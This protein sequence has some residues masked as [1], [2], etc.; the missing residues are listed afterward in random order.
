MKLTEQTFGPLAP[1]LL[2]L[3]SAF[4]A[5]GIRLVLV[6]GFGLVLRRQWR[7]E[8]GVQTLIE[9]VPPARATEDFDVLLKLEILEDPEQRAVVRKALTELGYE[10]KLQNLHFTK[11]GSGGEGRRDVKVDFLAPLPGAGTS[12]LK[13][14]GIRV[15][16]KNA[17]AEDSGLPPEK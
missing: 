5:G 10:P 8:E 1:H 11:P 6:G 17:T 9:A 14:A 7:Q 2:D 12:L 3:A 4:E 16:P 15:G 13:V